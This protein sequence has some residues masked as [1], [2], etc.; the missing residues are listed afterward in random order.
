[1]VN[2]LSLN[3]GTTAAP[4]DDAKAHLQAIGAG[5]LTAVTNSYAANPQYNRVGGR[6]GFADC[7]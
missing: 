3:A 7:T 5:D 6:A 2:P 1:M 4:A